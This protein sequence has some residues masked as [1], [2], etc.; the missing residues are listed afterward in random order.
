MNGSSTSATPSFR[1]HSFS[2]ETKKMNTFEFRRRTHY[3]QKGILPHYPHFAEEFL[4]DYT[5]DG[6]RRDGEYHA[7]DA[8]QTAGNND[9]QEDFDGMRFYACGIDHRLQQD[10]IDNIGS[11]K[12]S[13]NSQTERQDAGKCTG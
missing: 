2:I 3:T 5:D 7:G 1:C 8:E 11:G 13:G 10:V 4:E 12:N 9:Y 6:V